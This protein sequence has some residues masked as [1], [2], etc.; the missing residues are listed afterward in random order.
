[1]E[2][3]EK[4]GLAV[5]RLSPGCGGGVVREPAQKKKRRDSPEESREDTNTAN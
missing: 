1:M 3:G 4:K 5:L 2:K